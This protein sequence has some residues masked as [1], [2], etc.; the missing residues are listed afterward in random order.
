MFCVHYWLRKSFISIKNRI[1]VSVQLSLKLLYNVKDIIGMMDWS[2]VTDHLGVL[3]QG[4]I[5]WMEI[6]LRKCKYKTLHLLPPAI[7][8]WH[9][10]ITLPNPKIHFLFY[11][12]A[13]SSNCLHWMLMGAKIPTS[14]SNFKRSALKYTCHS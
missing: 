8:K 9:F 6:I 7:I 3:Q 12:R 10:H 11:K 1:G 13:R 14:I 5:W 2:V 4:M